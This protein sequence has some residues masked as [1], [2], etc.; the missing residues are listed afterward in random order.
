MDCKT[1]YEQVRGRTNVGGSDR[2]RWLEEGQTGNRGVLVL[3]R[4]LFCSM[5]LAVYL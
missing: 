1:Y 2:S 4:A 3:V 5:C